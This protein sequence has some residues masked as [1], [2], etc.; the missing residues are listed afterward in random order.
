MSERKISRYGWTPD[1]PDHRDHFY[2]APYEVT[3]T[4]PISIDLTDRCP[5]VYDQR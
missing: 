5:A 3:S 2:S 4:L 1:L